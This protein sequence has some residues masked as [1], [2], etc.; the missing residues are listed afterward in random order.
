MLDKLIPGLVVAAIIAVIG[1]TWKW[2]RDRRDC[3]T[4]FKFMCKSS[5]ATT[6]TFRAKEAISANTKISKERVVVLCDKLCR[7]GKLL[8]NEKEKDS[9]RLDPTAKCP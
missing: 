6:W 8:R 4:I 9:W 2:V 3:K 5:R 1:A 7:Q